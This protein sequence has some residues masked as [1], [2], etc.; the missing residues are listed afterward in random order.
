LPGNEK[1][2]DLAQAIR[3][4]GW[5]AVTF[6]YR[7]S[8]GSPGRFSFLGNLDDA[9]AVIAYLRDARHALSLRADPHRIVIAGHSMG[10][11]VA[12]ETGARDRTLAG[13]ILIS[14]WD[15]SVPMSHRKAVAM[16]SQDMESLAGVTAE[17]M[18][19]DVEAHANEM[20]L[21]DTAEG[22]ASKPL[23]VLTADDGLA[24]RADTLVAAVRARG[25]RD[26]R[27]VHV[28]TDHGWSDRR[29]ELETLVIGWLQS[30]K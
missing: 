17:S 27:S 16:M 25:S 19:A 5:V 22:L 8:W 29:I 24:A 28:S 3:R 12:A 13:S 30:L 14:A 11:W 1:N 20:R 2:L 15:P 23:L 6:N 9:A 10:G 21:S 26:V 7:G 18:A 4:A